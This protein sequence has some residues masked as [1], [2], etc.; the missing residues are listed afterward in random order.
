MK[1]VVDFLSFNTFITQ[2]V[3]IAFYYF[4]VFLI[5]LLLYIYRDKI[6]NIFGLS[7]QKKFMNFLFFIMLFFMMEIFLRMF[8]EAM[9]GF[10]DLHDYVQLIK[11]SVS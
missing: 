2:Y 7:S 3:L 6:N 8:F 10:F 9:I 11:S 1:A 5:P 4:S